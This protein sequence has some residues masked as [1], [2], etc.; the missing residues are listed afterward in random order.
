QKIQK[1][2]KLKNKLIKDVQKLIPEFDTELL[3]IEA[4]EI[5]DIEPEPPGNIVEFKRIKKPTVRQIQMNKPLFGSDFEKCEWLQQNGCT[6][7]EDRMWLNEYLQSEEY[8]N[9]Y[10]GDL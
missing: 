2:K 10:G 7:Q 5:I 1:K 8:K 3:R 6:C 9:L 4:E